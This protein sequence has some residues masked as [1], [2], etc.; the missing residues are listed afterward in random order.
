MLSVFVASWSSIAL[1]RGGSAPLGPLNNDNNDDNDNN[2][3]DNTASK[4][5]L[6]DFFGANRQNEKPPDQNERQA[7]PNRSRLPEWRQD[8]VKTETSADLGVRQNS[9]TT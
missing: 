6:G 4:S 7:L 5:V 8:R 1:S 9:E 2:D 3:N